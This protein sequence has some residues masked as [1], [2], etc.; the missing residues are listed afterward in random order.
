[1]M[2]NHSLS[3][4]S[5]DLALSPGSRACEREPGDKANVDGPIMDK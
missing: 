3:Q 1:M 5:V 4:V 2:V